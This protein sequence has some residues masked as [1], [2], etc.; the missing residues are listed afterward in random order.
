MGATMEQSE[1]EPAT[2]PRGRLAADARPS[3]PPRLRRPELWRAIAG[4]A[5]QAA[6][7]SVFVTIEIAVA[8][9]Q[10]TNY[11][12]RRVAAMNATVR[13]L[14]RQDSSDQLKLGAARERASQ[15][16][17]FE[18]LLFAPDLR[19]LRLG[20]PNENR[21]RIPVVFALR[22]ANSRSANRPGLR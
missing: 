10:R 12:N 6:L 2:A 20:P 14:R 18:R 22:R 11:V 8:L 4:M 16:L 5:V 17:V 21:S 19:T 13:E 15:G 1:A 3:R 9:S 7:G